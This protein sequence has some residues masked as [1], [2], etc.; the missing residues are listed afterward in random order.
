MRYFFCC[1]ILL[2][3]CFAQAQDSLYN[4]EISTALRLVNSARKEAGLDSVTL[5]AWLS[6]GCLKHAQYLVTNRYSPLTQGLEAHNENK[7]LQGCTPQGNEAGRSSVIHFVRPIAAMD[8]WLRTFYHRIPLLQ[9]N[10]KEIGIAYFEKDGYTVCLLNC[11]TGAKGPV[12]KDVVFCPNDG[13]RNI[14]MHMGG[15]IP[16]PVTDDSYGPYGFPITIYFTTY[17]KIANVVFVLTDKNKNV[18]DCYVSTPGKP[19][20]SFTQWNCICAIPKKPLSPVTQYFVTVGCTVN[21]VAFKKSYSFYTG[22]SD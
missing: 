15:E 8:G 13:Q 5:S 2:L 6:D 21:G 19:A 1:I 18:L 4:V 20:T 9:P 3:S 11:I 10:L 12:E 7:K 16:N 14:P 17:Q 22:K